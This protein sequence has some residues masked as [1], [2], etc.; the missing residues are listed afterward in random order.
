MYKYSRIEHAIKKKDINE[1]FDKTING[2]R[3]IFYEEYP[4]IDFQH[5]RVV[6]MVEHE[7]TKTKKKKFL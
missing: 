2:G 1:W 6:I 3:I 5:I 7:E 4:S